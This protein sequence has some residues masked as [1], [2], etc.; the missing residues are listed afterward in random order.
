M[1]WCITK[2]DII[3]F[4]KTMVNVDDAGFSTPAILLLRCR[5][6][7]QELWYI[8]RRTLEDP[9]KARD[10]LPHRCFCRTSFYAQV[11]VILTV[12]QD[13][14]TTHSNHAFGRCSGYWF[15]AVLHPPPPTD[16]VVTNLLIQVRG[17][18]S[19]FSPPFPLTPQ[20]CRYTFKRQVHAV[21][22][23][24]INRNVRDVTKKLKGPALASLTRNL[25]NQT[26]TK[27]RIYRTKKC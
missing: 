17:Q 27:C 5:S 9:H 13:S 20:F 18:C 15:R 2:S 3:S 22:L 26:N 1:K 14:H 24:L 12:P 10:L 11:L 25:F 6:L 19:I 16:V 4:V 8:R 7:R 23:F 21:L